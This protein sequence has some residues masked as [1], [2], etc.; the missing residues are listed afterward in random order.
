MGRALY[1]TQP[2][3]RAALDRCAAILDGHLDV[4]LLDLLLAEPGSVAAGLLDQTAYTQPALV[5]LEFALAELWR[6][7][8]VTPSAVLGHSVGEYTAAILAGVL[9]LEDGLT[10]VATRGRLMQRLPAGGAMAAIFAGS[11]EVESAV[12]AY[13]GD[14][15]VAAYNGPAHTVVTGPERLI[16]AIVE[17]F[18]AAGVRAQ[19]L[20]VSHAF[21]SSLLEPMLDELEAAA[22]TVALS[23]P[24]LRLISN[25]TGDPAGAEVTQPAY[26]RRQARE[27]VR[28]ARGVEHLARLGCEVFIEIGPQPTL[29]GMAQAVLPPES[30]LWLAS[31]RKGRDDWQQLLESLTT[32]YTH[33]VAIDWAGFDRP[34]PRRKLA[35]PTYP[36]QRERYWVTSQ[37]V[38]ARRP[39][40]EHPLLGRRLRSALTQ[41]Q[42]EQELRVE[43]V[44]YLNDHRVFGTAI[45]PATGYI[46]AALAAGA[47]LEPTTALHAVEILSALVF[48]ED[49]TRAV[50][51]VLTPEPAGAAF[52]ILSQG[53]D[54]DGWQLHARGRLGPAA[55][56]LAQ[57]ADLDAIRSRCAE[58]I[59]A[60]EHYARAAGARTRLRAQPAG[61]D[62]DLAG[63]R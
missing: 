40:G 46:E 36:F 13:G 49:E 21:H 5:A 17:R 59:S 51:T 58:T 29:I 53:E 62:P 45:L 22:G 26:W 35:L 25:L 10:L 32:L 19:R 11:V 16:Q 34:Y 18:T 7:W 38:H 3:F 54:E 33:G 12:A 4:P 50:Q 41:I 52:E 42:F 61:R 27:A 63:R 14:I 6:S 47:A 48:S 43:S 55:A 31:L 23:P 15:S 2:V 9:T 30:G 1:A 8:G 57:A 56:G 20:N 39:A 28:F 44:D 60:E 24:R 37:P